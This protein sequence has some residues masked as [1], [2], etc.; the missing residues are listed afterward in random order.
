MT[1]QKIKKIQITKK[2]RKKN[3]KNKKKSKKKTLRKRFLSHNFIKL[4]KSNFF[5][6][7]GSSF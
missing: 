2:K 7:S 3:K 4:I 5:P 6:T 1:L